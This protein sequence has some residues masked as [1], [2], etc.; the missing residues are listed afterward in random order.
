VGFAMV[1]MK[2]KDQRAFFFFAAGFLFERV[3]LATAHFP[4]SIL[5]H[6]SMLA[7]MG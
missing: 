5:K 7:V 1:S 6:W 2:K 4:I 3:L